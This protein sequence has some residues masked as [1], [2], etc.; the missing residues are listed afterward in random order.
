[1]YAL[2]KPVEGPN[3]ANPGFAVRRLWGRDDVSCGTSIPLIA[4]GQPGQNSTTY[5]VGA[6]M[7]VVW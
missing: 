5:C 4:E 3:S 1:M 6:W 2:E 7:W